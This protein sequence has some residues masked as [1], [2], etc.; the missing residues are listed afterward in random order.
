[1]CDVCLSLSLMKPLFDTIFTW[2]PSLTVPVLIPVLSTVVFAKDSLEAFGHSISDTKVV[3]QPLVAVS[4]IVLELL[5]LFASRTLAASN[6]ALSVSAVALVDTRFAELAWCDTNTFSMC[7]GT[8][9]SAHNAEAGVLRVVG[10]IGP[11][12]GHCC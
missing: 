3:E 12:C 6:T 2:T 1:M 4:A 5:W 8:R 9:L 11:C 10:V 7:L